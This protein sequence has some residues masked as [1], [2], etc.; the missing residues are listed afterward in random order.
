MAAAFVL[1]IAYIVAAAITRRAQPVFDPSPIVAHPIAAG[2]IVVDT[3]TIDARHERYWRFID[4]D[5][6]SEVEPPDTAGWDLAIRRFHIIASGGIL[7]LGKPVFDSVS[8]AP[9][10][11][12]VPNRTA[13]DTIN[14]AINHWYR[15]GYLSHLLQ[16][17]GHVY[18]IRTADGT[19]ALLEVL[20]YYCPGVEAG[21]VTVRYKY[22]IASR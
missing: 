12:Y 3:L 7:D 20:S 10:T 13:S 17:S 15:Y 8:G 16:P 9:D 18:A 5:R 22:P 1:A 14:P 19:R 2:S 6:R 21:C 11:G 4:L